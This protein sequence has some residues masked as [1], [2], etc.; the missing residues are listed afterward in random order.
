MRLA[1][2][3]QNEKNIE[4]AYKTLIKQLE[5]CRDLALGPLFGNLKWKNMMEEV[6]K[7][8]KNFLFE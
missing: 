1:F 6:L 7:L 5:E 2:L 3:L 4:N 8:L